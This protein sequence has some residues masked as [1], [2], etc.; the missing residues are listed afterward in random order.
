MNI[1]SN[2]AKKEREKYLREKQNDREKHIYNKPINNYQQFIRDNQKKIK[3]E[4]PEL[5]YT[6]RFSK[7]A[8]LWKLEKNS[9]KISP[10]EKHIYNKPINNYQQFIRDNQ[11]KI[12][13]DFPE[14]SNTER[15]SK[16]AALWKLDKKLYQTKIIESEMRPFI[17][18]NDI[19]YIYDD[20][21][22]KFSKIDFD[23]FVSLNSNKCEHLNLIIKDLTFKQYLAYKLYNKL[24]KS[25]LFLYKEDMIT[26]P[27][28]KIVE[29]INNDY[30]IVLNNIN[31][32]I[33]IDN[34]KTKWKLLK[35]MNTGSKD[36]PKS[37]SF[38]TFP[39]S[40]KVSPKVSPKA[41]PKVSPK[42]SPKKENLSIEDLFAQL[43]NR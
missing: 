28:F 13:E 31:V 2:S 33:F 6:E 27:Q 19:K 38:K 9:N 37:S 3:E 40:P 21:K 24:C 1:F 39:K 34:C 22:E 26:E 43:N 8:A 12:K 17:L 14:L 18:S 30:K 16:L 29:K 23:F 11:K 7:L 36:S 10:K 35:Y 5:S 41:S 4:F 15:F 32:K 25:K 20:I 42:A